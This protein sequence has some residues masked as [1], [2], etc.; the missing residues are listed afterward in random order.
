M[1]TYTV[2]NGSHRT[3]AFRVYGGLAR[4]KPGATETIN[5]ASVLSEEAIA[6]FGRDL[7]EI[8]EAGT[9]GPAEPSRADRL[10]ELI[11]MLGDEDYTK[12]GKPEVDAINALMGEDEEPVTAAER[13]AVWSQVGA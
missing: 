11:A 8:T 7:V 1:A 9:D 3:K 2:N 13:D 10:V 12:A 4:V 6:A 5:D